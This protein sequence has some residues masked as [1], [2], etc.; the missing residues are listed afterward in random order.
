M[1]E[2]KQKSTNWI[3]NQNYMTHIH[4][5][6]INKMVECNLLHDIINPP[7]Y[8]KILNSH[9]YHI[10]H[11]CMNTI[12]CRLKFKNFRTILDSGCTSTIV[13]GG[14]VEKM[15]SEKYAVMQ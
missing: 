7:K 15:H 1:I 5:K 14:L 3:E 6:D 8:N 11:E 2:G 12:H 9:Y 13:M 4:D 10:I